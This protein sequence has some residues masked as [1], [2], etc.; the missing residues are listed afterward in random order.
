MKLGVAGILQNS[1][2]VLAA[3]EKLRVDIRLSPT[4]TLDGMEHSRPTFDSL[5]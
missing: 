2:R 4:P 5:V 3:H 1:K